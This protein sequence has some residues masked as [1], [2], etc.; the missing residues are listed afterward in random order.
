MMI[1]KSTLAV[2]F[3]SM[4]AIPVSGLGPEVADDDQNDST[5]KVGVR[6][7]KLCE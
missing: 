4:A 3:L 1:G 5:K 7:G 2:L 6:K